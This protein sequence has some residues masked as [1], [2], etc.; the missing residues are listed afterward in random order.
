MSQ[1]F[2][3]PLSFFP[4]LYSADALEILHQICT[5]LEK[6]QSGDIVAIG[7]SFMASD[8]YD[9]ALPIT[10]VLTV[11]DPAQPEF[12]SVRLNNLPSDHFQKIAGPLLLLQAQYG[13]ADRA[14]HLASLNFDTNTGQVFEAIVM[15]Q[16]VIFSS[17]AYVDAHFEDDPS[18]KVDQQLVDSA[19]SAVYAESLQTSHEQIEAH[20]DIEQMAQIANHISSLLSNGHDEDISFTL[21]DLNSVRIFQ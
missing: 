18:A 8:T 19:I 3:L 21:P 10:E 9:A 11:T 2:T 7:M 16:G 6:A 13:C 14:A 12:E 1:Q 15:P 4:E 20:K 5:P 17:E